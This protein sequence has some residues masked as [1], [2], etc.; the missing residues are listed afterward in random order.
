MQTD[1]FNGRG[2]N[3]VQDL[4]VTDGSSLFMGIETAG[5]V[6]TKLL[7]TL[8]RIEAENG[9]KNCCGFMPATVTGNVSSQ[10]FLSSVSETGGMTKLIEAVVRGL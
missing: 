8:Q 10:F 7:A 3:Q 4:V 1:I 9:L 6:M 2:S 5:C